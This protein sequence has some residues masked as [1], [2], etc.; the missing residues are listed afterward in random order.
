MEA[1]TALFVLALLVGGL[2]TWIWAL[3]DVIRV[4]DDA[5]FRAGN[6]LIWVVVI[7]M[8]QLIGAVIYLAVGRP[9]RVA[10]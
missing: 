4:S 7:A 3:V 10:R 1:F 9:A 5:R 6:K 2:A 8:T